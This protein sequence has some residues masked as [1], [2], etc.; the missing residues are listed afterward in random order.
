M[1]KVGEMFLERG[2]H[3]AHISSGDCSQRT[4][5]VGVNDR[6]DLFD[7]WGEILPLLERPRSR[8][9]P[10]NFRRVK[11]RSEVTSEMLVSTV[12]TELL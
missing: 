8:S 2:Q 6:M 12:A 7:V 1:R 11:I 4:C 9:A 5:S 10:G 3:V